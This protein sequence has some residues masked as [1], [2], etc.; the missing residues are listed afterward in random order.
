MTTQTT[1]SNTFTF[2]HVTPTQPLREDPFWTW[3]T[4]TYT[5]KSNLPCGMYNHDYFVQYLATLGWQM[6]QRVAEEDL[7]T[8]NYVLGTWFDQTPWFEPKTTSDLFEGQGKYTLIG[9][10]KSVSMDPLK[11]KITPMLK[12]MVEK[13][14]WVYEVDPKTTYFQIT[15]G[16]LTAHYQQI[17]GSLIICEVL[18]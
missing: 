1:Q 5:V 6:P 3:L 8:L 4:R 12:D 16:K 2:P 18:P 14:G 11:V 15:D 7:A 13:S 17:L 9:V 10:H